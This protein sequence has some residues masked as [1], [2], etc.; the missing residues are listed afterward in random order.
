GLMSYKGFVAR[1]ELFEVAP[2]GDASKGS[3][4]VPTSREPDLPEDSYLTETQQ[5]RHG[6]SEKKRL[7]HRRG[8]FV[9]RQSSRDR[10]RSASFYS[11]PVITEFPGGQAI[12]VLEEEVR[13][14]E[15]AGMPTLRI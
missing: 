8:A 3:W 9:F 1:E 4:V 15:A 11:P 13:L 7:R 6:E 5:N 2:K 10:E 12:E 14:T